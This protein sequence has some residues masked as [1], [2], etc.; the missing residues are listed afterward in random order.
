MPPFS[1]R[2]S[3]NRLTG[4]WFQLS[5]ESQFLG[6]HSIA[7]KRIILAL[8]QGS[9]VPN[10]KVIATINIVRKAD[11]KQPNSQCLSDLKPAGHRGRPNIGVMFSN[12][13][14]SW[15]F[16]WITSRSRH[17]VGWAGRKFLTQTS[18][19]KRSNIPGHVALANVDVFRTKAGFLY[20]DCGFRPKY[21]A[22][23]VYLFCRS[24]GTTETCSLW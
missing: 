18:S 10:L 4:I 22:T 1:S 19:W 24:P 12:V 6:P 7:G 23:I 21:S 16:S 17:Q 13:S 15:G 20:H 5:C 2:R 14:S 8:M 9:Q 3:I 11:H